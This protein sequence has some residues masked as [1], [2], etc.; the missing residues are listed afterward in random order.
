MAG[1]PVGTLTFLLTDL[2]GSTQAWEAGQEAMREAMVQHDAL[3]YGAVAERSGEMVETGREGDSV[4]AVFKRATDAAA[5]ALDIQRRFESASWPEMLRMKVRIALHSGEAELR[6]GHYFGRPLNRCA[7][8]LALCQGG[9][10]LL[11]AATRELLL[12]DV[13]PGVELTDLGVHQLKD[14][15]RREHVF[16]LSDLSRPQ[17]FPPLRAR[18]DYGTNLPVLLTNFI[19][20]KRELTELRNLVARSR[21]LTLTGTGGSGKTRLAIQLALEVAEAM[22]GG[23]WLVDLAPVSDPGLVARTV[24]TALES[25]SSRGA[26]SATRWPT[27][28]ASGRCC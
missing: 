1:L 17:A 14:I 20:R 22:P 6:G 15:R 24:A 7:R 25:R 5:C 8:V 18:R 2:E 23:A 9:Q 16:Q 4:L 28:A 27:A 26:G 10:T 12:D 21:L 11:T 3:V 19:G 13:R